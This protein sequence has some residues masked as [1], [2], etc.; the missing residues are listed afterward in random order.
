MAKLNAR[1]KDKTATPASKLIVLFGAMFL[2]I[3]TSVSVSADTEK[4]WAFK[5]YLDDKHIGEHSFV[6]RDGANSQTIRS[7]ANFDVKILFVTAFSYRHENTETWQNGCLSEIDAST[8]VNGKLSSVEGK[9]EKGVFSMQA[10]DSASLL[11]ECVSTFAYWDRDFLGNTHLLNSQTGELKPVE[12]SQLGQEVY[13]FKNRAIEATR[14]EI[15]FDENPISLWYSQDGR[16]L[17]LETLAKGGR[18]LRYQP[19]DLPE[20]QLVLSGI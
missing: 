9:R 6:V 3:M 12:V 11:D 15:V 4:Q 14:Y 5:V 19:V 7:R 2:A 20:A 13:T 1:R 17:G 8:V 16:W 18:V 10:N